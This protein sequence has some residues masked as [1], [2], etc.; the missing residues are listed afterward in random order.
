MIKIGDFVVYGN[1]GLCKVT[2]VLVPPFLER[3]KE[4]DYFQMIS[5]ID[6]GGILYVPCESAEERMRP[7][8]S[9]AAA[10]RLMASIGEIEVLELPPGKKAE[11]ILLD[12]TRKNLAPE[13]MQLVKTLHHA[14]AK[15]LYQGKKVASMDERY[16]ATAE[17]LLY[18][19]LAFCTKSELDKVKEKVRGVLKSL[20]LE[21]V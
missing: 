19:E 12:I 15:R 20:P 17:K 10:K 11:P 14:K 21:M 1:H 6:K 7:V 8:I 3:G 18:S 9:G 13:M 4:K 2:G 16:L 5:V